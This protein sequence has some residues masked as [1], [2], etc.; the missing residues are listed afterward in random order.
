MNEPVT[1]IPG[2][3]PGPPAKIRQYL[4]TLPKG[5]GDAALQ[6]GLFVLA[7]LCYETVRGLAEGQPERGA[8]QRAGR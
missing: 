4:P 2:F 1:T 8:R 6:V 7:D 3:V 5:K